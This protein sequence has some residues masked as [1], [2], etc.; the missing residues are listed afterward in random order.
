VK[1]DYYNLLS[2][3][4]S[5]RIVEVPSMRGKFLIK[6][7]LCSQKTFQVYNV[8]ITLEDVKDLD[9]ELMILSSIISV[10]PEKMKDKLNKSDLPSYE[11]V[12]VKNNITNEERVKI[13][14]NGDVLQGVSVVT[15]YR[16]HYPYKEVGAAS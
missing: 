6:M 16:R 10:S 8:G 13:E 12:V 3:Y 7:E 15:S 2:Q 1:G 9:K 14:E 5:I 11:I 4:R